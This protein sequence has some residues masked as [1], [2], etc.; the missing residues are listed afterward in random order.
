MFPRFT[1]DFC[2]P[3]NL[4]GASFEFHRQGGNR[5]SEFSYNFF[6]SIKR[7]RLHHNIDIKRGSWFCVDGKSQSPAQC[8]I[9]L[10][11]IQCLN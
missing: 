2:H 4:N 11:F 6:D 8:I 9:H 1:I 10:L 3:L 5:E 7:I